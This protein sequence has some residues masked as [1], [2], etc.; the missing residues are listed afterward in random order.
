MSGWFQDKAINYFTHMDTK[1]NSCTFP[2][3]V[4]NFPEK[5]MC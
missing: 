1:A 4:V 2:E 5:Q 3:V